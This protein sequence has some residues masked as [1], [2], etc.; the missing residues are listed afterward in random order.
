MRVPLSTPRLLR[1]AAWQP[2]RVVQWL[3]GGMVTFLFECI[4]GCIYMFSGQVELS[5]WEQQQ[6][7]GSSGVKRQSGA[8]TLNKPCL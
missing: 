1:W 8:H 2:A 7:S 3:Y 4:A 5:F 6:G